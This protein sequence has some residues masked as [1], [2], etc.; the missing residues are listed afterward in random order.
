MVGV[1][2]SAVV[3]QL[4][5]AMD[6]GA[7]LNFDQFAIPKREID[8]CM[9]M[10]ILYLVLLPTRTQ[11][12]DAAVKVVGDKWLVP[13]FQQLEKKVSCDTIR[14][15]LAKRRRMHDNTTA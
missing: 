2:E 5:T 9:A 10:Q 13:V 8:V 15:V 4:V 14:V 3:H 12:I 7:D 11:A 1:T 6:D